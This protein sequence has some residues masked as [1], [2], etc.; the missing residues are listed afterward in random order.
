MMSLKKLPIPIGWLMTS[1]STKERHLVHSGL[2]RFQHEELFKICS[3]SQAFFK[4]P[5][6]CEITS[7]GME[8]EDLSLYLVHFLYIS[9]L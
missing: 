4:T 9:F 7:F 1:F 8:N 5:K 3:I 2:Y 6:G